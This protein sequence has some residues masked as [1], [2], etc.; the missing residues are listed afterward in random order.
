ML[1]GFTAM[2]ILSA[3]SGK[4]KINEDGGGEDTGKVIPEVPFA[5]L[6][7]SE[8]RFTV[9]GTTNYV[10]VMENLRKQLPEF[11]SLKAKAHKA[12]GYVKDSYG[13][14]LKNASIGISSS[15][16]GGASTP[17]FGR[18]NEKGYYEIEIPFGVARFYNAGYTIDYEGSRIAMGLYP[19]DGEL[20][21]SW[22]S[23]DGMVEH[24]VLLPFGKGEPDQVASDPHQPNNYF[25]GCITLSWTLNDNDP[26]PLP[27]SL[28]V[29]S[30]FEVKLTPLDLVHGAEKKTFIIRKTV[31]Y[32][33][34]RILNV[35]VGKY[36][37][38]VK[39]A[40]GHALKI[41][42]TGI[43]PRP[44]FGLNP[45]SATGSTNV[46]LIA[47]SADATRPLPFRGAWEEVSVTIEK[48]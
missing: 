16:V 20:N 36:K 42:E 33:M 2:M 23:A 28:P 37:L 3:C 21:N 13:R 5:Q 29:G 30:V 4:E 8:A 27:G 15:V 26:L 39:T 25:G 41:R 40:N 44:E 17:A 11:T 47:T 1:L 12:I 43:N 24:F 18:T 22:A 10:N 32:N 31:E 38:Q 19:A 7:A 46:T 6:P 34:L 9:N 48:P 45:K 35:P 14:P